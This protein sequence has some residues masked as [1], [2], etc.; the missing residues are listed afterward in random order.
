[1]VNKAKEATNTS[2]VNT[3]I[4]N[5]AIAIDLTSAFLYSLTKYFAIFQKDKIFFGIF[6]KCNNQLGFID[7]IIVAKGHDELDELDVAKSQN[8]LDEL[9]VA[10]SRDELDKLV[11]A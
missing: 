9:I 1:V 5:E 4:A 10:K 11:V 2:T 6:C 7:D 3:A 8:E